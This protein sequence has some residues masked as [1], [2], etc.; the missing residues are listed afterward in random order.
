[1]GYELEHKTKKKIS[2]GI[3]YPLGAT[4][5]KD[6]VNFAIYSQHASEVFLLLFD[7]PNSEPTDVIR[8]ENRTKYIWHTLVHKLKAGQIYG[9]KVKGDFNPANGMRFNENRLLIDPYA[10]ALTGKFRN[11]DNLLLSYNPDSP[12]KDLSK[13]QRDNTQ[14]VPKSIVV[15]DE[16]DWKGDIRPE[17]PLEKM[18][19]YE[20]HLKG[21]HLSHHT[22]LRLIPGVRLMNSSL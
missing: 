11:T 6:G 10:K 13:D 1:M 9:Y 17:I 7:K 12:D 19:I 22:A 21:F 5:S 15:D 2:A 4:L 16:F 8:L 18:I 14:I 20:V 3:Y